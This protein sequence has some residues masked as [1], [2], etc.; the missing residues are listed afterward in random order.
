VH[1]D[2]AVGTDLTSGNALTA[3]AKDVAGDKV[4]PAH[5][6]DDDASRDDHT[7]ES[8]TERFLADSFLVEVAE[9]VDTEHYHCK[10]Q[11]DEAVSWAEQ[12]PVASVK[13]AEE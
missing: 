7:P 9:H 13:A 12:W 8:K 1:S 10:S 6:E 11:S 3:V 2:C 5:D 4:D